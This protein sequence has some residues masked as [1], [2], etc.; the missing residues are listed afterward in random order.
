MP[1]SQWTCHCFP[2]DYA[3]VRPGSSVK[4]T[5]R[6][7]PVTEVTG[8][9]RFRGIY[10]RVNLAG[11]EVERGGWP[12]ARDVPAGGE[13]VPADRDACHP[14]PPGK[15]SGR[16]PRRRGPPARWRR[17]RPREELDHQR[18]PRPPRWRL[19]VARKW[20]G[21]V[22]EG[23]PEGD[24]LVRAEVARR[25]EQVVAGEEGGQLREGGVGDGLRWRRR[26]RWSACRGPVW[27]LMPPGRSR[28]EPVF[29]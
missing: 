28:N 8:A 26:R 11:E 17:R 10:L 1:P 16:S 24:R 20:R 21:L 5:K 4:D 14:R 13:V 19:I 3:Q 2:L 25:E 6:K 22:G 23:L 15:G 12:S 29:T 9:N 27:L 7:T 18:P